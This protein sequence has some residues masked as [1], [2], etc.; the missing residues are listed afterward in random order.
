MPNEH[1]Q[2]LSMNDEASSLMKLIEMLPEPARAAVLAALIAFVRV[3][4][5]GKEPRWI[6]RSLESVLC[7]L[8]AL[9]ISSLVQALGMADG[10][11]TFIGASVGLFG[12]D[13]VREWGQRFAEKKGL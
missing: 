8:I 10:W 9:G 11:S 12:A 6:R 13:K 4:Y 7:G 1:T 2:A 5:D 3:V